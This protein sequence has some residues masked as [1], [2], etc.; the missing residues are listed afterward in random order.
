MEW[1]FFFKV[2]LNTQ[3]CTSVTVARSAIPIR[4]S[5]P[6]WPATSIAIFPA[7]AT[8]AAMGQATA[9]KGSGSARCAPKLLSLLPN[10]MSTLWVTWVW[11][12]TSVISVARLLV[13]PATCGPTSRYI[14][15]S[16]L[17][18][19]SGILQHWE[20]AVVKALQ[21]D[22]LA[23]R[24]EVRCKRTNPAGSQQDSEYGTSWDSCASSEGVTTEGTPLARVQVT[25][26]VQFITRK[27]IHLFELRGNS[28]GIAW[29][30]R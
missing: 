17:D 29:A 14:Q 8:A 26:K 10:F 16:V 11:S 12:P 28:M 7:R 18:H 13:I 22:G 27:S 5:K 21:W 25:G 19:Q 15:V 2:F 23:G 3:M 1:F 20:A 4:N 6:T 9:K 24:A 30:S